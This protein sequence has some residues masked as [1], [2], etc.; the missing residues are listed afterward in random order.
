[1]KPS[2]ANARSSSAADGGCDSVTNGRSAAPATKPIPWQYAVSGSATAYA[3]STRRRCGSSSRKFMP[4]SPKVRGTSL[5]MSRRD[6]AG[7][8]PD[9]ATHAAYRPG[10]GVAPA[11]RTHIS[12]RHDQPRAAL[13]RATAATPTG[14]PTPSRARS[15]RQSRGGEMA[16]RAGRAR[17]DEARAREAAWRAQLRGGSSVARGNAL[18]CAAA[19]FAVCS[20]RRRDGRF[21][22][23]TA[24]RLQVGGES[25][26]PW[27]AALAGLSRDGTVTARLAPRSAPFLAKLIIRCRSFECVPSLP[28]RRR[29]GQ[30]DRA[31]SVSPF[32]ARLQTRPG[33][34]GRRDEHGK[35]VSAR[36]V[37]DADSRRR[38]LATEDA[39]AQRGR[40]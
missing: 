37:R 2:H 8:Q 27:S 1:M 35:K 20:S 5:S 16:R 34:S 15:A 38:A 30:L 21:A 10:G 3:M 17:R 24:Q 22:S 11:R 39:R 13:L 6:S 40:G 23:A 4:P 18:Q 12:P 32:E 25:S 28:R 7:H 36:G 29:K 33:A 9:A 14:A 19:I 26:G 31:S